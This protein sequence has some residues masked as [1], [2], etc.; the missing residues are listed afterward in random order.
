[1]KRIADKREE[2]PRIV[3][4][5]CQHTVSAKAG[6]SAAAKRMDGIKVRTAMMP[7]SSKVQVSHLL[8]ILDREADAVE[9]VACSDEACRLLNGSKRA[10]RRVEHA[11]RLLDEIGVGA[12]R[13]G[14][15]RRVG[16][17]GEDLMKL[18]AAR[19]AAVEKMAKNGDDQ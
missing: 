14:I 18:A 13:L 5:Y 16:L 4:L 19:A 9:V 17:S 10:A 12:E 15:S 2:T 11:R 8:Q 3:V 6:I 1:M 7:C